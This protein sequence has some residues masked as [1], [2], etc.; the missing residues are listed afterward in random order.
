MTDIVTRG[1]TLTRNAFGSMRRRLQARADSPDDEKSPEG[2]ASGGNMTTWK[3]GPTF[4]VKYN[5][6]GKSLDFEAKVQKNTYLAIAFGDKMSN[7]DAIHIQ[8]GGTV[9]TLKV[10]DIW[11]K[12]FGTPTVDTKQDL[13]NIKNSGLDK[14]GWTTFTFSRA[15]DT[16]DAKQDFKIECGKEYKW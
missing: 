12:S 5:P 16:G 15:M 6:A 11:A 4:T 2:Q 8:N 10:T 14:D 3:G 1:R 9:P 7:I 13:K